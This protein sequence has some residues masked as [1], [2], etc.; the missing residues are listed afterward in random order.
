V[1]GSTKGV[2]Q[3]S[4]EFAPS[5]PYAISRAAGDWHLKA[6]FETRNFPV[7]FTRTSNVYGEHQRLYRIIP[8]TIFS[9]LT[10]R[11]LPLHGGGLSRRS[12]I[13][14]ADVSHA[15]I[16]II[17][18]GRIG[19]SYH[20]STKD[21]VQISEVVQEICIALGAEFSQVVEITHDRIG[22]DFAYTLDSSKIRRELEWQ[23]NV[24]LKDGLMKTIKWIVENREFFSENDLMYRIEGLT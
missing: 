12:F 8:K 23:D 2:L 24:T 10:G 1:Y 19:D 13:H 21:F 20:I 5:T 7:I 22:K 16:K 9:I 6:F 3:E 15:L 18:S 17:E 14:I 4:W 11:K